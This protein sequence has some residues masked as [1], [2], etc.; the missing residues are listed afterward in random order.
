M[1]VLEVYIHVGSFVGLLVTFAVYLW[2]VFMAGPKF[3]K[4]REAYNLKNIIRFYNVFQVVV[5]SL[6]VIKGI[7]F[8]FSFKYLWKCER[9]ESF[10]DDKKLTL[11][12][13]F[14]LFLGLRI[15]EFIET[16]FFVLRKK[17]NQASFLH[18]FHHIGSVLMTWLFI[19]SH[20]GE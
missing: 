9:F 1:D 5:C 11:R 3:M 15:L 12:V 20:A 6:Y 7:E 4:P 19:V 17:Y 14:W 18:V 2:L 8:G 13:S 16:I 10:D